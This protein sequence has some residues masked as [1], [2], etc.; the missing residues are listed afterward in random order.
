MPAEARV[1][2]LAVLRRTFEQGSYTDRALHAGPELAPRDRALAMRLAYGAVQ[3][4]GTLDA[5][6]G[7][8]TSRALDPA[9]TAA[10]RLGLY[11][12]LWA[13]SA[14]HA[15]L[16]DAVELAKPSGG[17]TLVNAVLR[18]A[19]REGDDWLR[20]L[21]DETPERASVMHSMPLWIT[22]LWW[23]ELGADLARGLLARCNEPAESA[24]RANTL[25]TDAHTLAAALPADAEAC[26]DPP[27]AVLVRGGFDAHADPRWAA[28]EFMPQSRA[29]MLAARALA[30]QPGERVLDMCAA[31]GGK[32]THL[33]A[34]MNAEGEVVAVER[35]AGRARA[36]RDTCARMGAVNVR[37]CCGDGGAP[38]GSFAR[39][40]LDPPCTGLGTLH[41]RPDLRWRVTPESMRALVEEQGQLLSAA[42]AMLE[43]GGILVYSTCTVSARENERQIDRLQDEHP[44]FTACDLRGRF[45]TWTGADEYV[46]ALPNI[47][48]SDGFFIAAM[49][50]A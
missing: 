15:V 39:I 23:E 5:L 17:H 11:E 20:A 33:S 8:W 38:R 12:L 29:A 32:T 35:H 3:R 30:P 21:G 34:L 4:R 48:G 50:R 41:S 25:R 47:Q 43:P 27:E 7:E 9:V 24:L 46:R 45:P 1:R 26:D 40:L 37:V 42:A 2:A 49:T 28:G 22:A 6:I 19:T 10:L 18:R 31:P 14:P 44:D 13:G 16:N 36:L